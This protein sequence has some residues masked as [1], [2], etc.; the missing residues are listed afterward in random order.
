MKI[1]CW[2]RS[3]ADASRHMER[4]SRNLARKAKKAESTSE[5][6]NGHR[7]KND[8]Q[9]RSISGGD[10]RIRTCGTLLE[11][12]GLANRRFQPLSHVSE[13]SPKSQVLIL[14]AMQTLSRFIASYS[15]TAL[16]F[17]S[18]TQLIFAQ[19]IQGSLGTSPIGPILLSSISVCFPTYCVLGTFALNGF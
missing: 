5:I 16:V 9:S 3:K 4:F 7:C 2:T 1:A 14:T 19:K 13:Y 6:R 18:L 15:P 11:Y 8:D 10:D 12:N 17:N